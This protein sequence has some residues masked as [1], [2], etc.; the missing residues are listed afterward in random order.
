MPRLERLQHFELARRGTQ[1][2]LPRVMRRA[3]GARAMV[4]LDV[5]QQRSLDRHA[6]RAADVDHLVSFPERV[7]A[8][9]LGS[10][11]YQTAHELVLRLIDRHANSLP[12][13]WRKFSAICE[14]R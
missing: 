4:L 6:V 5:P 13:D 2:E 9:A 14:R 1:R 12:C 8:A 10:A 7:N 11:G 3:C